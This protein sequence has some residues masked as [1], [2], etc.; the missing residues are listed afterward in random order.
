M[1]LIT[2]CTGCKKFYEYYFEPTGKNGTIFFQFQ[3]HNFNLGMKI[4]QF[5]EML[6]LLCNM[7]F[8]I[9]FFICIYDIKQLRKA[10]KHSGGKKKQRS[11]YVMMHI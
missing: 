8:I 3:H 4:K 9:M 7:F 2:Q 11:I 5:I 10:R 6:T 1:E